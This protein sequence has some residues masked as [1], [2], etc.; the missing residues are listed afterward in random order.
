MIASLDDPYSTY[1][2]QEEAEG[3]NNTISSSFEGIGAQVEEKDGQILI[4]A[5]IK[6]SPAEKLV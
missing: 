5:P 6:G 2:D 3:F 4:V 1:M